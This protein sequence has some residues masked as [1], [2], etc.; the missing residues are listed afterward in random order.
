MTKRPRIGAGAPVWFGL[1]TICVLGSCGGKPPADAVC[2]YQPVPQSA[3]IPAGQ[4]A[5]EVLSSTEEYF[6][7]FD[8]SG[9]QTVSGATNRAV[10]VKPG[11]YNVKINNSVHA[12]AVEAGTLAKCS[13]GNLL[14]SG[15]TDEYY[16]VFDGSNTQ[17]A[18][19][20]LGK[21]LAFFPGAYSVRVN[22]SAAP[23]GL[24]SGSTTE[25][26]AGTLDVRGATDEYYYVFDTSGTQLSSA[27]L[28][29][30][31]SLFAGN[32]TVKVNNSSAPVKIAFGEA[33]DVGTGAVLLKG[34]TDEYYYVFDSLGKQLAS[35]KLGH[36][37]SL[38]PG[39]YLAKIN[40][41]AITV[42][43]DAGKTGEYATATLTTRRNSDEYYYVFDSNGTQL[44]SQKVNQPVAL[45]AGTYSV[46][47]GKDSRS[48]TVAA[49][50]SNV[51]NW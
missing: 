13:A 15:N 19:Q 33:T 27:K 11:S 34:T 30:A 46:K 3:G 10:A 43:A 25:V 38:A 49:G 16:Y 29:R 2:A 22:N 48:V 21:A 20:K 51:V 18:S 45:A 12:L 23:A 24:T 40:D 32:F 4:G 35:A 50:Q 8:R 39:T 36:A 44:I 28:S 1:A 42:T 14:V 37:L 26:K 31:L 9:K 7:V 41:T 17:L 47:N 6:Y 5:V